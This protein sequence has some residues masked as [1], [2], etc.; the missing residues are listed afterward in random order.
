MPS[1]DFKT[2][3]NHV[4]FRAKK[5]FGD[6]G[7]IIDGSVAYLEP[8]GGGPTEAHTHR[9]NHLFIVTQGEAKIIMGD[10]EVIV[11]ENE[12]Y[13]VPGNVPHSVWNNISATTVMIG[14]SV[15]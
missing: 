11:K 9:H 15:E 2:P 6:V 5:L 8:N 1:Q 3:P 7:R 4:N 12:S 13:L 14:V 10:K